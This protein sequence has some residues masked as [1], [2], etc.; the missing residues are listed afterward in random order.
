ML[1]LPVV[2]DGAV[3]VPV[4]TAMVVIVAAAKVLVVHVNMPLVLREFITI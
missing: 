1:K 3:V 2:E 4:A